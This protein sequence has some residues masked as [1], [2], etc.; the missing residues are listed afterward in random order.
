[1]QA[2]QSS[3]NYAK[4]ATFD[5]LSLYNLAEDVSQYFLVEATLAY[6]ARSK[7]TKDIKCCEFGPRLVPTSSTTYLNMSCGQKLL[8][9]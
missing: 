3:E 6:W 8:Y 5:T 2:G 1:M 9:N 7:V 4:L